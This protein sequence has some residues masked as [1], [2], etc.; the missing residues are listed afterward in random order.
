MTP[1]DNKIPVAQAVAQQLQDKIRSGEM[2]P[3]EKFPSQRILAEQLKVS[4]PSLREALLMLETL[5]LVTTLPARGTFV[6]DQNAV[7]NCSAGKSNWR[8]DDSFSIRDVFQSRVLI[9]SELCRLS[10]ETISKD[11]LTILESANSAFEDSWN[12]QDLMAHV[13]AD[14]LFHR[15]IAASCPNEMLQHI[16]NSVQDL[17]TESQ[18]Q[19]IPNTE[20]ARM[21]QSINEHRNI[22]KALRQADPAQSHRAMRLHIRNT[23]QCSGVASD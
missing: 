2:E 11:A 19:P 15:T 17:L 4:R 6:V 1:T 12:R 7:D 21:E 8:Y 3:G 14:L 9:E 22:I 13:E 10:A 23:A 5:G 18:R 16:Y 20:P